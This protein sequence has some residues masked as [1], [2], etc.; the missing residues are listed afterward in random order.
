MSTIRVFQNNNRVA[1]ATYLK[2]GS[3]LQV[4]PTKR[5]FATEA[6]FRAYWRDWALKALDFKQTDPVPKRTK[7]AVAPAAQPPKVTTEG[8]LCTL[9]QG[10]HTAPAGTYYIGDLCYALPRDV[11]DKVFGDLGGY[12]SGYYFKGADFFMMAG[13][14]YGDGEYRGS[15]GNRFCVDAGIIG[16]A[17]ISICDM[18]GG[19]RISG[20]HIYT[21]SRPVNCRFGG[22]V[23]DFYEDGY[24]TLRIDTWGNDD[25]DD[26]DCDCCACHPR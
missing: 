16:I 3:I 7:K 21:F 25:C 10:E 1:T 8:W 9:G 22:G 26:G 14:A 17:P 5:N 19:T 11:Y 15:D 2:N 4:Y 13:T 24:R 20:G 18:R 23:F 12:Q 6:E